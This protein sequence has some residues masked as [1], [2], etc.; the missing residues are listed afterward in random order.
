MANTIFPG[1][2]GAYKGS[3]RTK[4]PSCMPGLGTPR[5]PSYPKVN[6]NKMCLSIAMTTMISAQTVAGRV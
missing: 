1:T 2:V 3:V 5:P 6:T 4:R